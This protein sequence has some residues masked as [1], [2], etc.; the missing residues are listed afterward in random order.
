M[1]RLTVTQDTK[2]AS[3]VEKLNYFYFTSFS[4]SPSSLLKDAAFQNPN[5]VSA[6]VRTLLHDVSAE[7][8]GFGTLLVFLFLLM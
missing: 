7:Q 8:K 3:A 5:W 6:K 2:V 1:I 4:L